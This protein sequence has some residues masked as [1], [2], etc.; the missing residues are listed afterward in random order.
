MWRGWWLGGLCLLHGGC[1]WLRVSWIYL[2]MGDFGAGLCFPFVYF[3]IFTLAHFTRLISLPRRYLSYW[4]GH[5][6]VVGGGQWSAATTI[7]A[8]HTV[9]HTHTHSYTH[10]QRQKKNG[11]RIYRRVNYGYLTHTIVNAPGLIL[12]YSS[13]SLRKFT[14]DLCQNLISWKTYCSRVYF[15]VSI[16]GCTIK[17]KVFSSLARLLLYFS[18]SHVIADRLDPNLIIYVNRSPRHIQY[19][20]SVKCIISRRYDKSIRIN[21]N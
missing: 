14:K 8:G 13:F 12:S 10:R 11:G 2:Q 16:T 17:P 6:G 1:E 15:E 19:I 18:L 21:L 4:G 20:K 9:P 5:V 3:C 7:T